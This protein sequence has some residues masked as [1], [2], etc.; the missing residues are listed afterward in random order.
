[1]NRDVTLYTRK[2]CGICDETAAILRALSGSLR[3]QLV[4]VNVDLDPLLRARYDEF[5]PVVAVGE[6]TIARAPISEQE[7][8]RAL[9]A[10]LG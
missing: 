6:Q 4:E 5:V 2:N 7:L 1:M 10:A 9:T 8:R 3:F